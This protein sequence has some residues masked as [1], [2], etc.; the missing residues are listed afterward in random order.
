MQSEPQSDNS[1]F[2]QLTA[3]SSPCGHPCREVR[4]TQPN[5]HSPS[6]PRRSMSRTRYGESA[7][8]ESSVAS[9]EFSTSMK[10]EY[11]PHAYQIQPELVVQNQSAF[12]LDD[13]ISFVPVQHPPSVMPYPPPSLPPVFMPV[14]APPHILYQ[15]PHEA[16][17]SQLLVT[18][19]DCVML[20]HQPAVIPPVF[21]LQPNAFHIPVPAEH[22]TQ[23]PAAFCVDGQPDPFLAPVA[24]EP[25]IQL[26]PPSGVV[27]QNPQLEV[28]VSHLL[29]SPASFLQGSQRIVTCSSSSSVPA[30]L[31]DSGHSADQMLSST[32]PE[33]TVVS[34]TNTDNIHNQ[35]STSSA[36]CAFVDNTDRS[37]DT[38][39]VLASVNCN[40]KSD[41]IHQVNLHCLQYHSSGN[42]ICPFSESSSL[43]CEETPEK[44]TAVDHASNV[45]VLTGSGDRLTLAAAL[46]TAAFVVGGDGDLV[47]DRSSLSSSTSMSVSG[48][49]TLSRVGNVQDVSVP[50]V[51]VTALARPDIR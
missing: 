50:P 2:T 4:S 23:L 1:T 47:T 33:S 3:D 14:Q 29:P 16:Q 28:P 37:R 48:E 36:L 41:N 40:F 10:F 38:G 46:S 39:E 7:S 42:K 20:R 24:D 15:M 35:S 12:A 31:C 27:Y 6:P 19:P 5:R 8:H 30:S 18:P 25:S 32:M 17:V 21:H 11:I 45:I 43:P 22:P 49:V 44:C 26:P 34:A 9:G 51:A 13:R